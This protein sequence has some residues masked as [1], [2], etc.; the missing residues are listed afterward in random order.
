M[1][2]FSTNLRIIFI[3]FILVSILSCKN[4]EKENSSEA[5]K[6]KADSLA[7]Y[8]EST[9]GVGNAED[10]V[11]SKDESKLNEAQLQVQRLLE[12]CVKKDYS[13]A[14]KTI[15]Y[16]GADQ[17]RIGKDS[18]NYSNANEANTVKVTCD[19]ITGWLG[20]SKSYEFI[21]YNEEPSE[22]GTKYIVEVMFQKQKLGL[23]RHSFYLIKT[24]K[25]FLLADMI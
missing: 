14:S 10:L 7:L 1:K 12:S 5:E 16:R 22:M 4:K 3:L 24:S 6:A 8:N 23:D 9:T 19:V 13:N 25:G 11:A 21:S 2:Q 20:T 15:M 18:F 17:S